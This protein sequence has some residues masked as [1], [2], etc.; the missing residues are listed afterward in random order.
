[1]AETFWQ[2]YKAYRG[3]VWRRALFDTWGILGL[4]KNTVFICLITV[5]SW[6]ALWLLFKWTWGDLEG[7]IV[8]VAAF[9]IATIIV[10]LVI[11]V[12]RVIA[13]PVLIDQE[14]RRAIE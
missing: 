7:Q 8:P 4:N 1:M 3:R 9:A 11:L 13:A 2:Q 6:L 12:C 10:G 5:T 14:Q